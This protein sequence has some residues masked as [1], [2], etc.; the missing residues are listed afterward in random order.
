MSTARRNRPTST[1]HPAVYLRVSSEEQAR[2]GLGI[3]AQ[4]TACTAELERRGLAGAVEYLDDGISGTTPI[5]KRDGLRR[6]LA[7]VEAGTVSIVIT[8]DTSRIARGVSLIKAVADVLLA[9]AVVFVSIKESYID[10]STAVGAML[11]HNKIAIDQFESD[12]TSERTRAALAERKRK[13]GY[14][15]GPMPL[16]YQR[17]PGQECISVDDQAA[18]IVRVIFAQRSQGATMAAIAALMNEQHPRPAGAS[19]Y[20]STIKIILDNA[21]RYRGQLTHWP[22]ILH[23]GTPQ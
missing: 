12:I 17:P 2:S 7:D 11:F 10:T 6:L 4:R 15:A 1:A 22:A 9:H 16:G 21:P 8:L 19:W 13:H 18:G 23:E 5:A 20:A 3:E 14:A